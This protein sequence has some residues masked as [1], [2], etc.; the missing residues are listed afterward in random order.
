MPREVRIF[1]SAD[2]QVAAFNAHLSRVVKEDMRLAAVLKVAAAS[3]SAGRPFVCAC[4]AA[5]MQGGNV[6]VSVMIYAHSCVR[7]VYGGT[8]MA[9]LEHE[10]PRQR[11]RQG[12]CL[13]T[14]RPF[15]AICPLRSRASARALDCWRQQKQSNCVPE[16]G[17]ES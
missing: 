11:L 15:I 13:G 16:G 7:T 8:S 17:R 10:I 12:R 14:Q 9:S 2:S 4:A 1:T 5:A 3:A 6:L